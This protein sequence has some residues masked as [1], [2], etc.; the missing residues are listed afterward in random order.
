M[1]EPDKGNSHG[2]HHS[3]LNLTPHFGFFIEYAVATLRIRE[4]SFAVVFIGYGLPRRRSHS[5]RMGSAVVF[6]FCAHFK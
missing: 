6:T 5:Q 1:E 3:C 2:L 4:K